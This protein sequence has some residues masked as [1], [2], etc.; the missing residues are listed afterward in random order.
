M[1][2]T[3]PLFP[4]KVQGEADKLLVNLRWDNHLQS[5]DMAGYYVYR[6]TSYYQPFTRVSVLLPATD[7]AYTDTVA[8]P[9]SY[10]YYVAAVDFAENEGKSTKISVEATTSG[11]DWAA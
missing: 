4:D 6:G 3:P 11:V 10:Y 5:E 9:G 2:K 1:D 7:S 8:E